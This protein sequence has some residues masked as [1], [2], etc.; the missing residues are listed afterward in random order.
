VEVIHD[1]AG[2]LNPT[3]DS[4]RSPTAG[5]LLD[6]T[7]LENGLAILVPPHRLLRLD[8]GINGENPAGT[9]RE[10]DLEALSENAIVVANAQDLAKA[11]ELPPV[12]LQVQV[13]ELGSGLRGEAQWRSLGWH[14][15]NR[16]KV[17]ERGLEAH[18]VVGS[19]WA[20]DVDILREQRDAMG[21]GRKPSDHHELDP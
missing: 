14:P 5:P 4:T 6:R 15:V 12:R 7:E 13:P 11:V 19:D 8:E 3:L 10:P 16:V 1:D 21:D 17:G 9:T 20:A 18:E 2:Y